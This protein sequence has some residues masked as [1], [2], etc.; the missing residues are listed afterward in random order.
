MLLGTLLI[1]G[2]LLAFIAALVG[3]C[4]AALV[5]LCFGLAIRSSRFGWLAPFLIWIPSLSAG[6]AVCFSAC[7]VGAMAGSFPFPRDPLEFLI[8]LVVGEM[9]VVGLGAI[10]A[11]RALKKTRIR[12]TRDAS[13]ADLPPYDFP[14]R[15]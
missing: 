2:I 10:A 1:V 7:T 3:V 9:L 13:G 11:V 4:V 12:G 15:K 6:F 8:G 14:G 5:A